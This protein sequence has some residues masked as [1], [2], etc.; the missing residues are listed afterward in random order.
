MK[1]STLSFPFIQLRNSEYPLVVERIIEIVKKHNLEELHLQKSFDRLAA[2]EEDLKKI[3]VQSTNT[4]A[5][6]EIT[7]KD[8]LRDK[9]T[10][11]IFTIANAY[12][13]S[14][15]EP[16]VSNAKTIDT[17]FKDY[18]FDRRLTKENYTSQTEKTA[19]LID[20]AEKN[21]KI[22]AAFDKL[23]LFDLLMKLKDANAEVEKLFRTRTAE[24]SQLPDVD[25]KEIR[26]NVGAAIDKLFMMIEANKE[27]YDDK[28]YNPLIK[29]LKELLDYHR[30]Q[31]KIRQKRQ[32]VKKKPKDEVEAP[33]RSEGKTAEKPASEEKPKA[34]EKKEAD[35]NI[36]L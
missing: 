35:P 18:K 5:T 1:R 33:T 21:A 20:G 15:V 22:K 34:G 36:H 13:N 24:L 7:E 29:E 11:A 27:E 26:K 25:I 2:F 31:L 8:D 16:Q 17:Y 3:E 28:D 6:D 9:L 32:T 19:Q 4:A 30:T 14:G 10:R 12:K 23:H